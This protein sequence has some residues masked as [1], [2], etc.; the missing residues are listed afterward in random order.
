MWKFVQIFPTRLF[1]PAFHSGLNRLT[2]E[3]PFSLC[4]STF[5]RMDVQCTLCPVPVSL[6]VFGHFHPDFALYSGCRI[7]A[8]D[9]YFLRPLLGFCL[10]SL[11]GSVPLPHTE[12]KRF[13]FLNFNRIRVFADIGSPLLVFGS[14][15]S[16]E[17]HFPN[18]PVGYPFCPT[19]CLHKPHQK[20]D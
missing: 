17:R 16:S 1:D 20:L 15:E 5:S 14:Q 7:L 18:S 3:C 4:T 2:T 10:R 8:L 13:S 6:F 19:P 9:L 11:I 12:D